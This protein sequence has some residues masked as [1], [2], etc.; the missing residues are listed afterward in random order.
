M[1][2]LSPGISGDNPN[3]GLAMWGQGDSSQGYPGMN[4]QGYPFMDS[5]MNGGYIPQGP[6]ATPIRPG[7]HLRDLLGGVPPGGGHFQEVCSP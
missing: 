1:D 7:S 6:M 3:F 4:N 5:A 2:T